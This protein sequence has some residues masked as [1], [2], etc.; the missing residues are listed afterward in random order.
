MVRSGKTEDWSYSNENLSFV[1][2]DWVQT[3]PKEST[4]IF[5]SKAPSYYTDKFLKN[6]FVQITTTKI[7]QNFLFFS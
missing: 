2:P 4:E 5:L 7:S 3:W 6:K 1:A